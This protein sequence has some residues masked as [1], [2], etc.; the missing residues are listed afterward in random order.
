MD[1]VENCLLKNTFLIQVLVDM[2]WEGLI[3][4]NVPE[5]ENL[6]EWGRFYTRY[7]S[8]IE[9]DPVGDFTRTRAVFKVINF[10]V[11]NATPYLCF[12]LHFY[13]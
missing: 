7:V 1:G 9:S 2:V 12:L 10:I 4:K 6:Y 8:E 13:F 3:F 5:V 11:K